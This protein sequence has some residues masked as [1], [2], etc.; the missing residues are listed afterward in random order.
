[1]KRELRN[2]EA[3]NLMLNATLAEYLMYLKNLAN[4]GKK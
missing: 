1:M 4:Q 2:Q 3:I